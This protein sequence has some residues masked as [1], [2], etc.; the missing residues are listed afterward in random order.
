MSSLK[1]DSITDTA[2]SGSPA[3]PNGIAPTLPTAMSNA[4]ATALG[5]KVYVHGTTYNGGNAPT[6][7]FSGLTL[8]VVD[9]SAFVPYQ[10]QGGTWRLRF[11]IIASTT[12]NATTGNILIN[13]VTGLGGSKAQT[14]STMAI[15]SSPYL[16]A[17]Q[18]DATSH[19]FQ[20]YAN[21]SS[22]SWRIAGDV[23]IGAK[24]NW[25]Y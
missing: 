3:F 5:Y 19:Q 1:V 24:P 4:A 22:G 7:S 23:E 14:F 10:T 18:F 9:H 20:V 6:I 8:S 17:G 15:G 25:A 21:S 2:G 13:S 11:N 16:C 12:S